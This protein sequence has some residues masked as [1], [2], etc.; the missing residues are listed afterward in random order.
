MLQNQQCVVDYSWTQHS[1]QFPNRGPASLR[2]PLSLEPSTALSNST[3]GRSDSTGSRQSS[4]KV[5][6]RTHTLVT[7]RRRSGRCPPRGIC[8]KSSVTYASPR[9]GDT[10]QHATAPL[11][12]RLH[13][14][15]PCS[16]PLES[17][18]V[19]PDAASLGRDCATVDGP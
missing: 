12:P 5:A 10:A 7:S 11:L 2:A 19:R 4:A 14:R 13:H 6:S 3:E 9:D 16:R 1:I 18:V 8:R 15:R 17:S